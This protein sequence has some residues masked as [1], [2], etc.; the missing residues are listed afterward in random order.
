[1]YIYYCY[2][3]YLY[4]IS[5]IEFM[6]HKKNSCEIWIC[7]AEMSCSPNHNVITYMSSD[8]DPDTSQLQTQM[9]F[10]TLLSCDIEPDITITTSRNIVVTDDLAP[11]IF[12]TDSSDEVDKVEFKKLPSQ[13]PKI[14]LPSLKY[15]DFE[16]QHRL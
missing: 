8:I 14:T 6:R 15:H 9:R 16:T 3:F 5:L 7:I 13:P 4:F 2:V 12:N 1:M 10:A 11:D